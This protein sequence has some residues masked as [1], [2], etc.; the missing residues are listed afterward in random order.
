MTKVEAQ[1]VV[2][3]R[4]F[5]KVEG[6]EGVETLEAAIHEFLDLKT[7][8]LQVLAKAIQDGVL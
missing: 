6:L 7:S 2:L 5:E 3:K 8:E 4:L 1:H